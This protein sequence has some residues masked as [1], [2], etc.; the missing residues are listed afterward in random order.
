MATW[1]EFVCVG[2]TGKTRRWVVQE[3]RDGA[4][5]GEIRWFGRWRTYAFYPARETVYE[6]TCLGDIAA[7]INAEME[8]RKVALVLL[9]DDLTRRSP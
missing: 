5:L 6:P 7:F 2:D 8:K 9:S 4:P 3:K 1:I